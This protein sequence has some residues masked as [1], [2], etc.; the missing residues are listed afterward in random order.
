MTVG[1]EWDEMG[2]RS[3]NK[4]EGRVLDAVGIGAGAVVIHCVA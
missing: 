3:S 2:W 1:R 4:I